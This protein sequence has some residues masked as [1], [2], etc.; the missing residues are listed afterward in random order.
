MYVA[1]V[2]PADASPSECEHAEQVGRLL[3]ARGAVI[4]TGGLGGVMAAAARGC[5]E[6]GGT[7]VGLLPSTD[8][9]TGNAHLTV[10][11]PTGVGELR[12]GLVVRSADAVIAIGCNWG[13]LSEVAL[14]MR[15][16][17]PVVSIG[18]WAVT[19]AHGDPV[20]LQTAQTPA[21]AVEWVWAQLDG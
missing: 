8:R 20:A 17:V 5:A 19:D 21:Q 3:A 1:V 11:L 18:G 6:A 7:S 4:V 10:A 2:G 14:A 15:S 13:T 9:A 12:N 16:H